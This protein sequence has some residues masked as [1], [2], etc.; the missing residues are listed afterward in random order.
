MNLTENA[1]TLFL[2]PTHSCA[3]T[4]AYAC[5]SPSGREGKGEYSSGNQLPQ[6]LEFRSTHQ[7]VSKTKFD[8]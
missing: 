6:Q 2:S 4:A 3:L 8:D 1:L 5:V 7:V